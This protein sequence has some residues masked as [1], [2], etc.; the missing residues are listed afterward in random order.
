MLLK[1]AEKNLSGKNAVSEI[2][3][4][5]EK[6]VVQFSE[7]NYTLTMLDNG[8]DAVAATAN[9][10]VSSADAV[11]AAGNHIHLILSAGMEPE[12]DIDYTVVA[13]Q[14]NIS[15]I[16]SGLN[17]ALNTAGA[18]DRYSF[19]FQGE[20][21]KLSR[22]FGE[23]KKLINIKNRCNFF[24]ILSLIIEQ[25]YSKSLKVIILLPNYIEKIKSSEEIM[26]AQYN[27]PWVPPP[28][29]KNEIIISID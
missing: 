22:E 10:S 11:A 13:G 15:S 29:R 4:A 18:A 9:F 21:I 25:K 6:L 16:V 28:F 27:S 3:A 23:E 12:I 1:K 26:V 20:N 17:S 7:Q 24:K 2:P 19:S 14:T 5:G 8:R